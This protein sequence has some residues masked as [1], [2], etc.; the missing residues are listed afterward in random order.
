MTFKYN[1]NQLID[2]TISQMASKEYQQ[3]SESSTSDLLELYDKMVSERQYLSNNNPDHHFDNIL[4]TTDRHISILKSI[5]PTNII[6]ATADLSPT[7]QP[8]FRP[9][10]NDGAT[11]PNTSP[12]PNTNNLPNIDNDIP[13]P[14]LSSNNNTNS[15]LNNSQPNSPIDNQPQQSNQTPRRNRNSPLQSGF[16]STLA[17]SIF[18][19]KIRSQNIVEDKYRNRFH[20]MFIGSA[21]IQNHTCNPCRKIVTNE[22][23]ILRL[24]LLYITLHPHCCHTHTL[25]TIAEERVQILAEIA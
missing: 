7:P 9:Y 22:C 14:P 17:K 3:N 13:T 21:T 8:H 24:I 12:L 5:L 19:R 25:S 18:G 23:N 4:E 16:L 10:I 15:P 1:D 20:N 6:H 11:P 2:N